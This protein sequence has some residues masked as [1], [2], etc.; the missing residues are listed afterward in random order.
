MRPVRTIEERA[1][2]SQRN[3]DETPVGDSFMLIQ[4]VTTRDA[5]RQAADM[6]TYR[7]KV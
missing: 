5:F 4:N 7:A 1:A 2:D 3:L 6:L